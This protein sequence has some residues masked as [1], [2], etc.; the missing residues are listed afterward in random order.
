[1]GAMMDRKNKK[2]REGRICLLLGGEGDRRTV[3]LARLF[4]HFLFLSIILP[5]QALDAF[6]QGLDEAL[7]DKITLATHLFPSGTLGLLGTAAYLFR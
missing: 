2:P 6:A 5:T 7:T 4:G 3:A 1:M